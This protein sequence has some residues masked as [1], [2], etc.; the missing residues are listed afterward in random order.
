MVDIVGGLVAMAGRDLLN[1]FKF[2]YI[3]KDSSTVK[4]YVYA[5]LKQRDLYLLYTNIFVLKLNALEP[6]IHIY[7]LCI[8]F[9]FLIS[10]A[11]Q[12]LIENQNM[13]YKNATLLFENQNKPANYC[14][15]VGFDSC[16]PTGQLA[17]RPLFSAYS[18]GKRAKAGSKSAAQAGAKKAAKPKA[19]SRRKRSDGSDASSSGSAS[20]EEMPEDAASRRNQSNRRSIVEKVNRVLDRKL[21]HF[22]RHILKTKTGTNGKTPFQHIYDEIESKSASGKGRGKAKSKQKERLSTQFW[23]GF[24]KTFDLSGS[25]SLQ[26]EEPAVWDDDAE[27]D[28]EMTAAIAR[29]HAKNPVD[30]KPGPL[31]HYIENCAKIAPVALFGLI[32]AVQPGPTL[33]LCH[34]TLLHQA[35]AKYCARL[36]AAAVAIPAAAAAVAAAA[37]TPATAA[38]AATAATTAAAAV[39]QA[40]CAYRTSSMV[41]H[42]RRAMRVGLHP[43]LRVESEHENQVPQ[44]SVVVPA[45]ADLVA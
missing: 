4:M 27:L 6:D 7:S 26:L 33:A 2:N 21:P 13:L 12:M 31:V 17:D 29:A 3:F 5:N 15:L 36:A 9:I 23:T 40:W 43:P 16:P 10:T 19:A 32:N 24:W 38:A 37:A 25:V 11:M 41:G 45:S 18:M 28:P 35:I 30:R 34:A 44:L 42:D 39:D 1:H 22:D 14:S 20:E 8:L